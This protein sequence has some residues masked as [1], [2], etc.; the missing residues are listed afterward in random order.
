MRFLSEPFAPDARVAV[1]GFGYVGTCL[2][3]TLAERGLR[4]VAV[5]QNPAIVAD[6]R[7]GRSRI[8]EPGLAEAITRVRTA[9]RLTATTDYGAVSD[10]DVVIVTVG[11]PVTDRGDLDAGLLADACQQL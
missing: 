1:V 2:G 9:E 6:L 8:A 4:V 3:V 7:A 10:V 11:T 5:E